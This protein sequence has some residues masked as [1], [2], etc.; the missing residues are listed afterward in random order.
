MQLGGN[1]TTATINVTP[2]IDVLLVLI[3][4]FMVILPTKSVGL[5]VRAP[6]EDS[7]AVPSRAAE[8]ALVITVLDDGGAML[9]RERLGADAWP[10]RLK[11]VLAGRADRTV[12]FTAAP[13]M[14]FRLVGV[15]IDAARRAGAS[16]VGL[17]A[18]PE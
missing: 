2:L 12:F 8:L 5:P 13:E 3:I 9:N 7:S 18:R 17:L 14:E 15:A 6:Q 10:D 16:Q 11:W 4:I 1:G